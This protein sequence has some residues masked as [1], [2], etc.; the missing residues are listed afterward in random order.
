MSILNCLLPKE[1]IM[2]IGAFLP[3]KTLMW[4]N[5][6]FYVKFHK[7][8]RSMINRNL[9]DNYIRDMIRL[10]NSFV[11]YFIV[12]ENMKRWTICIK[13]LVYK[14]VYYPNF[15]SF[16]IDYCIQNNATKCRNI[17]TEF[18]N[19]SGLSK[20]QHKKNRYLNIRWRT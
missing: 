9:Y 14:N 12:K 11:F 2:T 19:T 13:N 16:V 4:L 6:V 1:I 17:V 18:L 20:N 15:A 8:V 5:K 10:D 3:P 7:N